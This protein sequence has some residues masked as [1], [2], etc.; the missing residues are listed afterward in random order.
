LTTGGNNTLV[1][2]E[3]GADMTD[4]TNNV[5]MG[6]RAGNGLTD[7]GN[8]IIGADA[9]RVGTTHS[10][11]VII[12]KTAAGNGALTADFNVIIGMQAGQEK[13]S[14]GSNV[15]LGYQSGEQ[16]TTTARSIFIGSTAGDD[17]DT[18]NDNLGIGNGA[19]GGAIAGGEFNICVGRNTGDAITSG[20]HNTIMGYTAGS[21]LT[22]GS[23]NV[24][25]GSSNSMAD[26]THSN[27]IIIGAGISGNGDRFSFGKASNVVQNTFTSDANWSRTSDE[28]LK[29]NITSIDYNALNFINELRPVT[30]NWKAS[31]DVPTDMEQHH[32]NKN[33]MDTD[34]VVDFLIAQEVKAAM[35]KHSIN[36]F[37]GWKEDN[38]KG[39][40]QLLSK[41]SFVVPLIKAVQ[42]LSAQVTTLQNEVNTLKGK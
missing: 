13:T 25:L 22:T 37:S 1:G 40:T 9:A 30:F 12:G 18:E 23:E 10:D 34:T 36:N 8:V 2:F 6:Y 27:A 19:L 24:I 42:E 39:K 35:D 26:V 16:C 41:E 3:A 17:H 7:S 29:T 20:D 31:Q 21:G 33:L 38:D 15:F 4:D 11:N 32:P 28:R 14:G 5:V